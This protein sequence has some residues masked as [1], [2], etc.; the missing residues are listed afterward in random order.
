MPTAR[1]SRRHLRDAT[2]DEINDELARRELIEFTLRTK[3]DYLAGW[4]HCEVAEAL[5]QFLQ[6]VLDKKSP[7]LIIVS[8][9]QQGKSEL[10]SRRM[11]AYAFGLN[12]E[13]RIAG[14]AYSADLAE[15]FGNDIQK[16]I[17]TPQ[18]SALFP[19][20]RI[21][22]ENAKATGEK[23]SA[24]EF[25]IV[26]HRGSYRAVGRGGPLTGRPV[27]ILIGDDFL[28]D[29]EEA[30]SEV[31]RESIWNWLVTTA[32][33][34]LQEGGGAIIM[35]TRWH[36]DD[37]IGRLIDREKGRWKVITYSALAEHD[38]PHRKEGEPL[39]V[40]RFSKETLISIRDG[41]LINSHQWAAIYQGH[42][43]P[44]GGGI[45]KRDDWRLYDVNAPIDFDEIIQSWDMTFKETKASDKVSGQVWGYKAANKYLIDRVNDRMT[46]GATKQA[47]RTMTAKHP[48]SFRK[49]IEDK[50][51]GPAVI[52]DMCGEISGM[53][54]VDPQGGKIS[55]AHAVSGEVEAHNV[56]LPAERNAQGFLVPLPW[57]HDFIEEH[58][59]FPSGTHDD[60]VDACTQALAQIRK[61]NLSLGLVEYLKQ[62]QNKV[63][64]EGISSID[65]VVRTPFDKITTSKLQKPE[66]NDQTPGCPACG[67]LAIARIAGQKRCNQC[68]HQWGMAGAVTHPANRKELQK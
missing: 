23:R 49:F 64:A 20:S 28:K 33:S 27:D 4:F 54:A 19:R 46:F 55:R 18:Y 41:G 11:P 15:S 5:D 17:D 61:L 42:P 10:V 21:L 32:M 6:D 2:L 1:S 37:A 22:A 43:S 24:R 30:M 14:T 59:A 26:G 50:A 38:E 34:R 31:T 60:D 36:M 45:F 68:G 52:D 29:Y 57:V 62:M 56:Y 44:I 16:I 51:N 7:R 9:P 63:N 67:S 39:S 8:P 53:I 58:A 48:S 47:V 3:P 25:T 12:P 40:E 13:W 66:T 35:S 65:A